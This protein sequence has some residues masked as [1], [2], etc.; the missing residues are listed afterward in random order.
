MA[1]YVWLT[2]DCRAKAQSHGTLQLVENTARQVELSQ[3]LVGF[4]QM[5]PSRHLK[6]GRGQNYRLLAYRWDRDANDSVIAFHT[7]LS[8][9]SKDYEQFL[10]TYDRSD[11]LAFAN[12]T[13]SDV[14]AFYAQR[15]IKSPLPQRKHMSDLERTWLYG[16]A[17]DR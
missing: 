12:V 15:T 10:Q 3:H 5:S 16:I 2:D 4:D 1:Y 6:R 9:G 7:V 13:E 11:L 14:R 17:P 8:R